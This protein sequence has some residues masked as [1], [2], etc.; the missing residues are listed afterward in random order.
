MLNI[1]IFSQPIQCYLDGEAENTPFNITIKSFKNIRIEKF[2]DYRA[3][4]I[5]NNDLAEK[6]KGLTTVHYFLDDAMDD[7]E[8]ILGRYQRSTYVSGDVVHS[9]YVTDESG[10]TVYYEE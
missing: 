7:L 6:Q 9:F 8:E 4:I 1:K 5:D 3:L 2:A 10:K